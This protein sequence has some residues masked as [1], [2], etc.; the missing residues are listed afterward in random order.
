MQCRSDSSLSV[1]LSC[2]LGLVEKPRPSKRA[3]H[4]SGIKATRVPKG[5]VM[6]LAPRL[7]LQEV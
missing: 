7:P 6:M 4:V 1:V 2:S 3:V 5:G